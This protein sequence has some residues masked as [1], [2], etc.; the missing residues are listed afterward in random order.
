VCVCVCVFVC[1]KNSQKSVYPNL[2]TI[3]K[4]KKKIL[5]TQYP[6][7]FTIQK[8]HKED[9]QTGDPVLISEIFVIKKKIDFSDLGTVHDH[10]V[11]LFGVSARH[12]ERQVVGLRAL[13]VYIQI[14][15]E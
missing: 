12:A 2:R 15:N 13:Y 14:M 3:L 11:I 10:H 9:F 1:S 6:S 4:T 7:T 8:H 5:R